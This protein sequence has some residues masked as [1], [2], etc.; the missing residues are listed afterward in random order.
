MWRLTPF[1]SRIPLS[2]VRGAVFQRGERG[3]MVGCIVG[4]GPRL[5]RPSP[6]RPAERRRRPVRPPSM[7]GAAHLRFYVLGVAGRLFEGQKSDADR[8]ALQNALADMQERVRRQ[9]A[10]YVHVSRLDPAFLPYLPFEA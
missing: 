8:V 5:S 6:R 10:G 4:R 9:L 2:E 3:R 1:F 7:S